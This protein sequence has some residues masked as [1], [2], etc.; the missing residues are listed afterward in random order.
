M[1]IVI[2]QYETVTDGIPDAETFL[3]GVASGAAF[4]AKTN[5]IVVT[6]DSADLI[7]IGKDGSEGTPAISVLATPRIFKVPNGVGWACTI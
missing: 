7:A 4:N 5:Y 6:S 3:G 2:E 1:A